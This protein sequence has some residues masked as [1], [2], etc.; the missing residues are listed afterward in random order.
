MAPVEYIPNSPLAV[1]VYRPP[2]STATKNIRTALVFWHGVGGSHSGTAGY[3]RMA[4]GLV[5]SNCD[6]DSN[7]VV[8]TPDIR[9]HGASKGTARGDADTVE[10]VLNDVSTVLDY[11]QQQEGMDIRIV[12]GGHALGGGLVMNYA[13]WEQRS[14]RTSIAAYVLLAPHWGRAHTTTRTLV[15]PQHP[16]AIVTVLPFIVHAITG[17]MGHSPAV[18][19]QY[20]AAVLQAD[21]L[22][23]RFNTVN[24]ANALTAT[25]PAQQ[26]QSMT[27]ATTTIATSSSTDHSTTAT[28]VGVWVG[29]NDEVLFAERLVAFCKGHSCD[30]TVVPGV[31]HLGILVNAHSFL[32]P[33]IRRLTTATTTH[34]KYNTLGAVK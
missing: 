28:P 34:R 19:F 5:V 13:T 2:P 21:P 27:A 32:G 25:A 8:Y 6:N 33:W 7:M 17:R 23:V 29:E 26:L 18:R 31:N 9:G 22:L 3:A 14:H 30:S 1:R 15:R 24:M 4:R 12:L 10:Q 11:V 20:P 16:F